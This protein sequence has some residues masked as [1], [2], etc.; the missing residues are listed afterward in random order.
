MKHI[1]IKLSEITLRTLDL[2]D[3][4]QN[5]LY[6][7]NHPKNNEYILAVKKSHSLADLQDFI[8]ACNVSPNTILLGIFDT[9]FHAHIGNIKYENIDLANKTTEMGILIGERNYRGRG[10]AKN[11][12]EESAKWLNVNLSLQTIFL[13]VDQNNSAALKL[14]SKIG[15]IPDN[16]QL[17]NGLKM[18]W[19]LNVR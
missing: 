8:K 15:F 12:I 18:L 10:I 14:Y 16:N 3:D 13:R 2:S 4:L 19:N 7:M 17:E 11:I 6:W 9:T 1:E 5:Y